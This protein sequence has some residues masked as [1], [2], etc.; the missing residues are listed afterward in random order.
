MVDCPLGFRRKTEAAS[1]REPNTVLPFRE[2]HSIRKPQLWICMRQCSSCRWVSR[3]D[4]LSMSQDWGKAWRGSCGEQTGQTSETEGCRPARQAQP[5]KRG[6]SNVFLYYEWFEATDALVVC[7]PLAEWYL[8]LTLQE[9]SAW[10]E[11]PST[12]K[13]EANQQT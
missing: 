8:R 2:A 1:K 3:Q 6:L 10:E 12:K 4:Y 7:G 5:R 9:Q 11:N 13:R